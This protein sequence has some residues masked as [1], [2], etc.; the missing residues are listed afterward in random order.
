LRKSFAKQQN[1]CGLFKT[2][3]LRNVAKRQVFF[4]N[5]VFHSLDDA[6]RFYVEREAK[7]EAWYPKRG[8][9]IDMYNDL[10]TALRANVDVADAPF[11]R[12]RGETPALDDNEIRD[13]VAFLKTLTDG[14]HE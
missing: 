10:P 12:K 13:I 5:G 4:H 11:D 7:P 14:Y 6:V 3:T 9:K 8:G 1:Y 2:P